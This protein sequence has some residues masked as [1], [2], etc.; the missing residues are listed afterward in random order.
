MS[1]DNK[2]SIEYIKNICGF[3]G[4]VFYDRIEDSRPLAA[5][6]SHRH[7]GQDWAPGRF[8]GHK[9]LNTFQKQL[10][11]LDIKLFTSKIRKILISGDCW[12]TECNREICRL[13]KNYTENVTKD[14]KGLNADA[15]VKKIRAEM[16]ISTVTVSV[17][18]LYQDVVYKLEKKSKMRYGASG[19][20]RRERSNKIVYIF[21]PIYE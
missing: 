12:T 17:N 3:Y 21:L 14:G 10:K 8:T 9:S 2:P 16:N 7:P 15:A 5:G 4:D 1:I 19:I 6:E 13:Y 20:R 11:D 18:L